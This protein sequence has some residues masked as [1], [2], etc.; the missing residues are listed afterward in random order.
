MR[1]LVVLVDRGDESPGVEAGFFRQE[2]PGPVDGLLLEIVPE[3]EIPQ[4]L[5]EGEVAGGQ[6]HAVDVGRAQALLAGGGA[7]VI[8]LHLAQEMLFELHHAGRS[9]KE[10]GVPR[11]DQGIGRHHGVAVQLE[12]AQESFAELAG[13]HF[14][15]H[16]TALPALALP[17]AVLMRAVSLCGP[18]AM[19][20]QSNQK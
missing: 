7:G 20:V 5:E 10:R 6:P 12:K 4:H 18:G 11:R 1:F 3:G 14:I 2:F 19:A 15:L 17:P 13:R 9:E 8:G 16:C